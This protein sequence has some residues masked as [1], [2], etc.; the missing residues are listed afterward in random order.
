MTIIFLSWECLR[1]EF[2]LRP[3]TQPYGWGLSAVKKPGARSEVVGSE[4]SEETGDPPSGESERQFRDPNLGFL[5][6]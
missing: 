3:G 2:V 5:M 6:L 4:R 1:S